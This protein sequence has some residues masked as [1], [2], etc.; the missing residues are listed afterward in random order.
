MTVE[1]LFTLSIPIHDITLQLEEEGYT[2]ITLP[3]GFMIV[4]D[5]EEDFHAGHMWST[6]NWVSYTVYEFPKVI[7]RMLHTL[8]SDYIVLQNTVRDKSGA[9]RGAV[10]PWS[11]VRANQNLI[12]HVRRDS[13]ELR[14][15]LEDV[16]EDIV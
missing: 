10:V 13:K 8:N 6:H 3:C 14:V 5:L 15:H 1:E 12:L 9:G 2:P 4:K 7:G 16:L 11:E